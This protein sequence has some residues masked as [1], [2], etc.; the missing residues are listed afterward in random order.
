MPKWSDDADRVVAELRGERRAE[1]QAAHLLG[2][3]C[4]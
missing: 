1:R 3:F 4:S 2:S